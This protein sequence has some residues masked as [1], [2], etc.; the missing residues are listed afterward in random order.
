MHDYRDD[1]TL[2]RDRRFAL[3]LA[4]RTV[5]MLASSFAPVALAFGVLDLPGA[6]P[7]TLS[8]VLA[9]EAVPLVL[10]MLAGGVI[11]DRYPRHRVLMTGELL[12]AA[13]FSLLA[14]MLLRGGAPVWALCGA[15]AFS[16]IAMAV[17]W[18]ALTGI[19]PDV[20]P[21]TRLQSANALIGLGSNAAR[22]TG[23][24]AS[25]AVVVFVGAGWALVGSAAMFAVAGVLVALLRLDRSHL[26]DRSSSV[27][28][29]LR[30]GWRE[31]S[32]RSWL[33]VVV[34][35]FSVM[36]MALQAAHGV[37]GPVVARQELG[38]AAAWSAVLAGE[39]VGMIVG[40][41]VAVRLRPRR[42][43]LVAT[44]FTFPATLPYLL[45][46]ASAPLWSV[47]LAAFAMGV[48][49]D[50]FGVLWQTSLQREVPPEALSRVS[51]Y[52]ALGSLMLGPI[53]LL[54]AG[55]AAVAFGAHQALLGCAAIMTL[56][57]GLALLSR[58]VRDMRP[59]PEPAGPDSTP[60]APAEVVA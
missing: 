32:S 41:L 49:F 55:P 12:S 48:C 9:A 33:W 56:T 38:G 26:A 11:A 2:M 50:I 13:A 39:A 34:V 8:T 19:I 16:G 18:P 3:L 25:G 10:F 57:T 22:V 20:V 1:L 15:A 17:V 14:T 23:L 53:G 59:R 6:T 21:S 47:V 30:D 37:L 54:I 52:D 45:L 35:Q 43:I 4:A 60:P 36:V 29:D 58:G 46:G 27:V 42:P 44:L 24:V 5:S 28:R 40:V 7:S 51:S 31:F